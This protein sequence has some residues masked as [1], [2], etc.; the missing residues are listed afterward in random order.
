MHFGESEWGKALGRKAKG[1]GSG[2]QSAKFPRLPQALSQSNLGTLAGIVEFGAAVIRATVRE[3]ISHE[4]A[5]S[6]MQLA[7]N[8]RT[9]IEA[10]NAAENER[11]MMEEFAGEVAN[12]RRVADRSALPRVSAPIIDI[13]TNGNGSNGSQQ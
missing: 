9:A 5:Q 10:K 8:Q 2:R 6:Y 3:M 1:V 4:T 13:P 7:V 11:R 12:L